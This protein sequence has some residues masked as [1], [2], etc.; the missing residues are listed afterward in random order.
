MYCNGVTEDLRYIMNEEEAK[1]LASADTTDP[2]PYKAGEDTSRFLSEDKLK[3]EAIDQYKI[4]F[5]GASLLVY[6]DSGTIEPQP[7][8]DGPEG[9]VEWA[10][11]LVIACEENGWWEEDEPLMDCL[12]D[13]WTLVMRQFDTD[14]KSYYTSVHRT[15]SKKGPKQKN[16]GIEVL[17]D[18]PFAGLY[19]WHVLKWYSTEEARDKAISRAFDVRGDWK[20]RPTDRSKHA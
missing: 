5:P 14:P 8:L 3:S 1:K 13:E 12:S 2:F 18:L 19:G 11:E 4:M 16:F 9:A 20:F 6:G 10:E 7:I 17:L 15:A